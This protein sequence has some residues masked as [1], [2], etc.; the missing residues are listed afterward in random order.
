MPAM[1]TPAFCAIGLWITLFG[2]AM[3]GAERNEAPVFETDVRPIFKANCF[4]C[5][6]EEDKIEGKLDLRL[7]RLIVQGGENGP[8]IAAGASDQS[9]LVQKIAAGE[10][11]P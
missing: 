5:H 4:H 3:L 9:L 6:G 11:P 2:S 7:A 8:A 10:M 1:N